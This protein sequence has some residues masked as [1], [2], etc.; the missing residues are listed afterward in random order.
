[1]IELDYTQKIQ[2]IVQ[3]LLGPL[4]EPE[5]QQVLRA[6]LP[7]FH[8]HHQVYTAL[9][10]D[11]QRMVQDLLATCERQTAT[12]T[13][14]T[15]AVEQLTAQRNQLIEAGVDAYERGYREFMD[16]TEDFLAEHY[17]QWGAYLATH[18]A[19]V[20]DPDALSAIDQRPPDTAFR[21]CH[22]CGTALGETEA[23]RWPK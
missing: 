3:Q 11:Y 18:G 13:R 19:L 7:L 1:M 5:L 8:E 17:D 16:Y 2:A 9:V 4:S 23:T 20:V 14:L 15:T 22:T 21:L 10:A 6:V 12:V